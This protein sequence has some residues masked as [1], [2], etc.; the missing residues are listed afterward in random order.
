MSTISSIDAREIIDSRGNPTIEVDV[1]LA[2]GTLGRAS[3]PSGASCGKHEAVELRDKDPNRFSG[4]G[5]LQAIHNVKNPIQACLKG[6]DALDQRKIDQIM[7]D[8][9]GTQNKSNL[10]ANAMLGVSLAAAKAAA[11]LQKR[12]LFE[13]IAKTFDKKGDSYILP[14]PMV[15]VLNGGVHADNLLEL[16]EFMIVPI[17]A[18]DFSEAIHWS[19]EIFRC[20]KDLLNTEKHR[21]GIGDEGGL[22]PNI[23]KTGKAMSLL[24]R[25]I[26]EVSRRLN[27]PKG[28]IKI[29]VDAAASELWHCPTEKDSSKGVYFLCD[30]VIHTN[31]MISVWK[32]FLSRWGTFLW[33]IEDPMAEDDWHGWSLLTKIIQDQ[34]KVLVNLVGDDIFVTNKARLREGFARKMGNA[35]LIKPNQVGTVTETVDVVREAQKN[36]FMTILSHRSGETEDTSIADLCVG[37]DVPFIKSGSVCRSERLA[38]YNRLLRI[39]GYLQKKAH[40]AGGTLPKAWYPQPQKF[41]VQEEGISYVDVLS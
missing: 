36:G 28:A 24:A 10:G 8:T 12:E 27:I 30:R 19:C 29:S 26:I 40:Y 15:N 13:H 37:L 21:F 16:Q 9:D 20:I 22:V 18:K 32:H 7:I 23:E 3:V 41:R 4:R 11:L 17:G 34:K 39:Q 33:S 2:S 6:V 14:I 1:T 38:K 31:G 25:G 5:V 35:I